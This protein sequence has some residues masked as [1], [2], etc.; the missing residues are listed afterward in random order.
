LSYLQYLRP[1]GYKNTVNMGLVQEHGGFSS[2]Y[3]EQTD[4]TA[5][6]DHAAGAFRHLHTLITGEIL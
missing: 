4:A 1:S 2:D 5:I 3:E 6:N